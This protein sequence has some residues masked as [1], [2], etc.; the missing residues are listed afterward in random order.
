MIEIREAREDELLKIGVLWGE[1]MAYNAAFNDSFKIKKKAK[2]IFAKEMGERNDNAD[3]RLAVADDKGEIIGFCYSYISLKPKYFKL[4]KFGFIGD[5]FVKDDCRRK[6]IGRLLVDDA[7]SF[8][9]KRKIK[10]IEL[11]VAQ[12]NI[13]TIKFWESIG[14]GHLLTWM[15]KRI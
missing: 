6:G 2:T 1:F 4:E 3:C 14:F 12:K 9:K 7:L 5:L 15:F 13:N 8:F 10:Q 11:L